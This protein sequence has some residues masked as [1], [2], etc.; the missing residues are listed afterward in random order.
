MPLLLPLLLLVAPQGQLHFQEITNAGIDAVLDNIADHPAGGMNG[1]AAIGDLDGDG[2]PDIFVPSSGVHPDRIYLNQHD[3]SFLKSFPQVTGSPLYRGCGA[4]IA[5]I[6]KDG[7][8]DIFVSSFGDVTG[9][10]S[11]PTP[12]GHRLYR[13]DGNGVFTDIARTA[14]VATT[15]PQDADGFGAAF[16]DYDLDGDL[17]L[18]VCGWR[19]Q[20]G[21]NRL[22]R[23]DGSGH[24]EDVTL[25]AGVAMMDLNSF[26]PRFADLDGDRY[27]ELLLAA[28]YGTTTLF[29]NRGNGSF[30]DATAAMVP[31]KVQYGMGQCV[32][33]FN[34]DGIFDWYVSS[35]FYQNG[36][37]LANGNRLYLTDRRG[38]RLRA[39]SPAAG[40]DDG[41]W[42]WGTI[43]CD[44]DHDGDLDIAEVNG[45][46]ML[47]EFQGESSYLFL[48][49]GDATF[50]ESSLPTGFRAVGM[51]RGL[52]SIDYDRDGDLDL[53]I[54]ENNGPLRLFRNDLSGLQRHW[55]EIR[56]DTSAHPGL[57]PEGIGAML[58]LELPSGRQ[59]SAVD[60]G[61]SYLG[62][63]QRLVHFG[64]G[65]Q[66]QASSLT[67]IWPDGFRTRLENVAA[68]QE[69]LIQAQAPLSQEQ[70]IRPGHDFD[71]TLEGCLAGD[72]VLFLYSFAG[73]G[74]GPLVPGTGVHMN[75]RPPVSLLGSSPADADGSATLRA[76]LPAWIPPQLRLWTQA[77]VLRGSETLLSNVV[78]RQLQP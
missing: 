75:L 61:C 62:T 78:T 43:G 28:D 14:G 2:W 52:Y 40:V 66:Q 45:W 41:G 30:E 31:D 44:F 69:L 39:V 70:S 26:S 71:S 49:R 51:G 54:A 20:A 11:Q 53:L 3:G 59:V 72:P 13:N 18:F 68:D 6:D 34:G 46:Q 19:Q 21:G 29:H 65:A 1:G 60:S 47:P 38:D 35:I 8:M 15:S 76:Q 42:G 58:Q 63:S 17:D 7:D 64:L 33:D 24:F 67:V 4:A 12:G 23:N 10:S 73:R 74:A 56:C 16:G 36:G 5:D 9:P 25:A 32:G 22:F 77:V 48:N 57:A 37:T 55:L 27:P 50:V